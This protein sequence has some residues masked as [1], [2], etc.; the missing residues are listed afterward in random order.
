V[1]E[2]RSVSSYVLIRFPAVFRTL[3]PISR[4]ALTESLRQPVVVLLTLLGG[5]LQIFNTWSAAYSLGYST[6]EAAEVTSD[7]KM[8]LDIGLSTLFGIGAVLA[9]FL[10]S[11]VLSREVASKTILTVV[12]KPVGRTSLVLGKFL[13]VAG[14]VLICCGI[15]VFFFLLA[16]RH[17]V[18]T[19]ATDKL[20][21]PVLFFGGLALVLSLGIAGWTNYYY[22]WSF[23]QT[24]TLLLLPLTFGAYVLTLLVGKGWVV[25]DMHTAW[26][27]QVVTATVAVVL[28]VLVLSSI[29][30]ALSTRLNQ[31]LTI[32]GC[33][34][35]FVAALLSNA[36][37]GRGVFRN[38]AIGVVSKV[39]AVDFSK[40]FVADHSPLIL[41]LKAEP[42]TALKAGD[43]LYYSPSPNGYPM[44]PEVTYPAFRG[45]LENINE[46]LGEAAKPAIIL[47]AVDNKSIT[48]RN[49]GA[50]PVPVGRDPEVGDYVFITPTR[51]SR[52]KLALWGA[53]PNLQYFWLVD[54][55]TQNRPVPRNYLFLTGLYTLAQVTI[56]LSLAVMLFQKRDV[57]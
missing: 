2:V 53:I 12:S 55:V 10:A 17:E 40:S 15:Q 48:V 19:T 24:S 1:L 32:V 38:E 30:V 14:A 26:K 54:A 39:E 25:Q 22:G 33:F 9:G 16:I 4:V 23:S 37:L 31:V 6:T 56:F 13:G 35:V 46:L 45:N 11:S 43:P 41:E 49:I 36:F 44:I 5:V 29:A 27:P 52:T 20:D 18:M 47:T 57:G 42:K 3:L 28:A 51:T 21:M 50:T 7:N 8:L 34:A